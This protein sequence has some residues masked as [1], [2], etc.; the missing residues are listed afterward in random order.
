MF[1]PK[2]CFIAFVYFSAHLQSFVD[3]LQL[4]HVNCRFNHLRELNI[5]CK[6]G[7]VIYELPLMLLIKILHFIGPSNDRVG[8]LELKL[9]HIEICQSILDLCLSFK[10]IFHL[11]KRRLSPHYA[12]VFNAS[13]ILT[14]C[15]NCCENLGKLFSRVTP[16]SHVHS[17]HLSVLFH[18]SSVLSVNQVSP[19]FQTTHK[20]LCFPNYSTP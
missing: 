14:P 8:N 11:W 20:W 12:F 4:I 5:F 13:L 9:L 3:C 1:S 16:Y 18:P 17:K 2:I 6:L 19:R 10:L 15:Q 7:W